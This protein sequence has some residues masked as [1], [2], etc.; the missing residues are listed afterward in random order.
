[1]QFVLGTYT[2]TAK[3]PKEEIYGLTSQFRRASI[4]IAANVA[5]GFAKRTKPEKLRFLNISQA[6]LEECKYYLILSRDLRF[7]EDQQLIDSLE[8][9]SRVLNAYVRA[10]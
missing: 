1:H 8:E 3:F 5:E 10:I 2:F 4:S 7:N 6:S 9:V